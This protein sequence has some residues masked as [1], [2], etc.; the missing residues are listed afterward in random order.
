[1]PKVGDL[2]MEILIAISRRVS[3]KKRATKSQDP[4]LD[5]WIR[6]QDEPTKDYTDKFT[7]KTMDRPGW[8]KLLADV[9]A[10][11][12]ST[13]TREPQYDG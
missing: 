3:S 6:N 1:M 7:G 5:R 8:N 13:I 11:N 2:I 9:M 4:D 12:V 10:G